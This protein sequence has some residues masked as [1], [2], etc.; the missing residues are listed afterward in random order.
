MMNTYAG[1]SNAPARKKRTI[2]LLADMR[3]RHEKITML[4]C[5]DSSFAS[6]MDDCGVDIILVGDSLGM[7]V[8]GHAT[9]LPVTVDDIAYHTACVARGLRTTMLVADLPFASYSR[10]DEAMTNAAQLMRAGA[11]MVKLEGGQWLA[12]T[13]RHLVERGIPVCA[14]LGLTPQSVHQLG[15]FR[16]QGKTAAA[17]DQ[18][19]ADALVLEEAGASLLVVEAVPAMLGMTVTQALRIPV[20]G[21]GAGIDCSGQVLVMH[22]MLGIFPGHRPKF[23]KNFMEG[24]S[25]VREAFNAYV[26][27]V[28]SLEFPASEHCF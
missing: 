4:T 28:R 5:Y 17:A 10:A 3:Q 15:G 18:L 23:V 20:I 2:T 14:H 13:V 16:V 22:D 19:L 26:Q 6:L 8:Q 11:E 1:S 21:I 27:A 24:K 12:D 25:S 7:V 9:T